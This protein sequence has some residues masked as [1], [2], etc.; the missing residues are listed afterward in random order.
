M[1]AVANPWRPTRVAIQFTTTTTIT[2]A[3]AIALLV[4]MLTLSGAMLGCSPPAQAR[5]A[6]T[7]FNAGIDL[8]AEGDY[9]AGIELLS[10][11]RASARGDRELR[12]RAAMALGEAYVHWAD[13]VTEPPA[14]PED[15]IARYQRAE[16][17][18]RDA[19]RQ[20]EAASEDARVN[21]AI[22]IKKRRELIDRLGAS[23][24]ELEARL[25]RAID[26]QRGVRDQ[27]R[28]AEAAL[29]NKAEKVAI[30][31]EEPASLASG[32]RTLIADVGAIVD[33]VSDERGQL[34]GVPD[35]ERTDEQRGRLAQLSA[36]INYL[37]RARTAM[38]DVRHSLRQK[39]FERAHRRSEVAVN[40]LIRAREQL[41]DPAA[42]LKG[43][44]SEE[45]QLD[46]EVT[47]L[48]GLGSRRIS[49]GEEN[50][51]EPPP[52]PPFLASDRLA[53]N[54]EALAERT[55]ELAARLAAFVAYQPT[56]PA[57]QAGNA[58]PNAVQAAAELEKARAI[59]A[60]ATPFVEGA[61]TAMNRA[62]ETLER[63]APT[64]AT[65]AIKEVLIN[66][67]RA[68]EYFSNLRQLIELTYADQQRAVQL[69]EPTTSTAP[70][71][72]QANRSKTNGAKIMTS[73]ERQRVLTEISTLGVERLERMTELLAEEK[74]QLIA[75]ANQQQ[76]QGQQQT[77]PGSGAGQED[78]S[79]KKQLAAIDA[80]F[81]Q[82]EL[83]RSA[84]LAAVSELKTQLS[85]G[86]GNALEPAKR[87]RDELEELRRLFFSLIEHLKDL[88]R[89]QGQTRDKTAS[90]QSVSSNNTNTEEFAALLPGL[91][92]RQTDHG[93]L[94]NQIGEAL[95]A[96]ADAASGQQAQ[97]GA[98]G[99]EKLAAASDEVRQA[100]T[101]MENAARDLG[102]AI[103][104][105]ASESIDLEPVLS[106]Q[107][108][109][110]EHLAKAIELLSP[111]KQDDQKQDDQKQDDQKQDD[112]KQDSPDQQNQNQPQ[113][114]KDMSKADVSRRLRELRERED[115][116]RRE[117]TANGG[118]PTIDRDW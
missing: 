39:S 108:T 67:F 4:G 21:L 43:L 82:A 71:R 104:R 6:R 94:A 26:D 13:A 115:K 41:L 90:A 114:P 16:A 76:Q 81:S 32:E 91:T 47:A 65:A 20:D 96:Q 80:R 9:D 42:V 118:G 100:T 79:L 28:T 107:A 87:A 2:I 30:A 72:T 29:A 3:I 5:E 45:V 23:G 97:P 70:D 61:V 36:L 22:T 53:A 60:Q 48:I 27:L 51:I 75:S 7:S 1:I 37:G 98:P 54:Q 109:A 74:R 77:Q 117:R 10:K 73:Q 106:G 15:V 33:L 95:A 85:A 40:E 69:L 62:K 57:E 111:P 44:L 38:N 34:E 64:Q 112:Q 49:L 59:L 92:Q 110:L 56:K 68:I 86:R 101:E 103:S 46:R 88:H 84:A 113:Q 63:D 12:F 35:D 52:I 66:L 58:D 55:A 89:Q 83:H 31:D 18:F 19:I 102:G 99:P 14:K 11:A 105:V 93:Q 17:W 78:D 50:T 25:Q 116:R 24:R 8:I